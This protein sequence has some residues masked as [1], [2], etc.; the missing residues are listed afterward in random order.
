MR[1]SKRNPNAPSLHQKTLYPYHLWLN[2]DTNDLVEGE[3]FDRGEITRVV[4]AIRRMSNR[5]GWP[6]I[7]VIRFPDE[8]KPR[9]PY[10]MV[11]GDIHGKKGDPIPQG[12]MDEFIEKGYRPG[13]GRRPASPKLS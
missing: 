8:E 2:T 7:C 6:C 3:D 13:R 11:W 10:I 4:D 5:K 12:I 1:K 9:R